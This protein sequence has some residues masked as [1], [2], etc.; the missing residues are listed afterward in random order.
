[1]VMGHVISCDQNGLATPSPPQPVAGGALG[2][3]SQLPLGRAPG[4]GADTRREAPSAQLGTG[5]AG[6]GEQAR[7]LLAA[8]GWV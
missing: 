5:R 4:V 8:P 2:L 1:M 7:P 6:R 3:G